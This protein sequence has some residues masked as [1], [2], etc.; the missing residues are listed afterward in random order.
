MRGPSWH[1]GQQ[2]FHR[3]WNLDFQQ[4]NI[5]LWLFPWFGV[6]SFAIGALPLIGHLASAVYPIFDQSE[7]PPSFCSTVRV[8]RQADHLPIAR[9]DIPFHITCLGTRCRMFFKFLSPLEPQSC[10]ERLALLT[11]S[12]RGGSHCGLAWALSSAVCRRF[13]MLVARQQPL[14]KSR[15]TCSRL[16]LTH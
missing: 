2:A 16:G 7:G 4:F 14:W 9:S 15:S 8:G 12:W 13:S 5:T 1:C 11:C 3:S 10:T 6:D